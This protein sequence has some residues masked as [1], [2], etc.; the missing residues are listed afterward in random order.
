MRDATYTDYGRS[1][2]YRKRE[3]DY[4]YPDELDQNITVKHASY[5]EVKATKVQLMKRNMFTLLFLK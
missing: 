1:G 3:V 2:E 5:V 4:P